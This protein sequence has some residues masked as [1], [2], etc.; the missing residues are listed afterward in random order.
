LSKPTP[1]IK[2][3]NTK[4]PPAPKAKKKRVSDSLTP[5][6][7]KFCIEYV[8]IGNKSEAYRNAYNPKNSKEETINENASRLSKN[9]KVL[10]RVKQL[11]EELLERNKMTLDKVVQ[12]I[13]E[14]A[15]FDIAELY[16]ENNNLKSI[17]DIPA[18]IR[19]A[20]S[21]IKTLEEFDGFGKDRTS[22]GFTKDVKIINKME[23]YREL[24]KHFGGYENNNKQK[25]KIRVGFGE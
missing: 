19:T 3:A 22:I 1:N 11:R 16:D 21:G 8:R 4:K 24:M 6:Q 7:E 15:T 2:R 14:I 5:K 23:A 12:G 18:N 20:I 13:A 25:S 17:H 9:S 10:A